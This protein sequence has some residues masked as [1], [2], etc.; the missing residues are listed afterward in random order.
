M[1]VSPDIETASGEDGNSY[2]GELLQLIDDGDGRISLI[3]AKFEEIVKLIPDVV[4]ETELERHN[5]RLRNLGKPN[6]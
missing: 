2:L 3:A 1:I 6:A 4:S 5:Q